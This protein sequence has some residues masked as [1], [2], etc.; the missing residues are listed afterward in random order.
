MNDK[1]KNWRDFAAMLAAVLAAMFFLMLTTRRA[2]ALLGQ[3]PGFAVC[4]AGSVAVYVFVW[5]RVRAS[6]KNDDDASRD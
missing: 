3:W 1:I 2:A 4:Y 6:L 5:R